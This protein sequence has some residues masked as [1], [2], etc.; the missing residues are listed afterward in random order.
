M[1]V[2]RSTCC[3]SLQKGNS[4]EGPFCRLAEGVEAGIKDLIHVLGSVVVYSA[5]CVFEAD[6]VKDCACLHLSH[7]CFTKRLH[8]GYKK[9]PPRAFL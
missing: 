7:L 2:R 9:R 6:F 8:F 5:N 3:W 1:C 4:G